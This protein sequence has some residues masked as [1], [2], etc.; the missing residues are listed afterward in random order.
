MKILHTADWHLG[1]SFLNRNREEE[2]EIVLNEIIEIIKKEEIDILILAGDV[3]DT[4]S[5]SVASQ[6]LYYD[7]WKKLRNTA[8]THAVV[9]GGNHDSPSVLNAPREILQ[10]LDIQVVGAAERLPNGEIDFEKEV[11]FLKDSKG[12]VQAV[13]CAVPYLRDRDLKS[14]GVAETTAQRQEA[15]IRGIKNHYTQIAEIA[16]KYAHLEIPIL[17]TGHL[18][19]AGLDI[20]QAD[21]R[22]EAELDIMGNLGKVGSDCFA[23]IFSYVALGHIHKP[24]T[25]GKQSRIR[26]SGSPMPLSFSERKDRKIVLILDYEK[27]ILKNITEKNIE[28]PRKLKRWLGTLEEICLDLENYDDSADFLPCWAE[29]I[30][31]TDQTIFDLDSKLK[32]AIGKKKIEIL[33]L[34]TEQKNKVQTLNMPEIDLEY[35]NP[36]D[37]FKQK[38][39]EVAPDQQAELLQTFQELYTLWNEEKE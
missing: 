35:L 14:S 25:V 16:Q 7:F 18:F 2:H 17:A 4:G 12:E 34:I 6:R 33:K 27:G 3:F 19:A 38:M 13:V 28:V 22:Q 24:Q 9:V 31:K 11:L 23:E 32:T 20:E 30:I 37:V 1:Q 21:G 26:Y 8:C 39:G 15:I 5:P 29:I 10:L 36:E